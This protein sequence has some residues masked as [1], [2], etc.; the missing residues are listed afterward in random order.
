MSGRKLGEG[1]IGRLKIGLAGHDQAHVAAP[2]ARRHRKSASGG[3]FP[4]ETPHIQDVALSPV[5]ARVASGDHAQH[6]RIGDGPD[7]TA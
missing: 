3:V 1:A 2:L 4:I 7:C 6:P 5:A